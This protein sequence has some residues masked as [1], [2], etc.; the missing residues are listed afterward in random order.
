MSVS[1]RRNAHAR[2]HQSPPAA[3]PPRS[4]RL[5]RAITSTSGLHKAARGSARKRFA[6][7]TTNHSPGKQAGCAQENAQHNQWD[8]SLPWGAHA[9]LPVVSEPIEAIL[10]A[11][12]G[13]TTRE[14]GH[15]PTA[16]VPPER[17][18]VVTRALVPPC[19]ALVIPACDT[20]RT[21]QTGSTCAPPGQSLFAR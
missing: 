3:S 14:R 15:D 6:G 20:M 4:A 5:L 21:D 1:P 10:L 8:G 9:F 7:N 19:V 11:L 13:A 17:G 12:R 18:R 16:P 2:Q